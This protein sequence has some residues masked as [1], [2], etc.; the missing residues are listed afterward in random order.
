MDGADGGTDDDVA[1][2][3]LDDGQG[4]KNGDAAADQGAESAGESGNGDLADDGPEHGH[5]ELELVKDASSAPGANDEE[6]EDDEG[7]E[8]HHRPEEVMRDGVAD[9]QNVAVKGGQG[10]GGEGMDEEG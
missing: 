5:V 2:G 1:G 8:S 4:L 3:F 6:E 7:D 9:G 10:V